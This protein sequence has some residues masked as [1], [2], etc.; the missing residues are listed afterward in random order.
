MNKKIV[1]TITIQDQVAKSGLKET[2]KLLGLT[3]PAVRQMIND[4]RDIY[5]RK[6]K[7]QWFYYETKDWRRGPKKKKNGRPANLKKKKTASRKRKAA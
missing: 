7:G 5:L 4:C 1:Y 6:I 3:T 2:A